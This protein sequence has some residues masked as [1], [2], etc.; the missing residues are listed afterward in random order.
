M[1]EQMQVQGRQLTLSEMTHI[2]MRDSNK[3]ADLLP[4][5]VTGIDTVRLVP[6]P[7]PVP[8]PEKKSPVPK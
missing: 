7:V 2:T 8:E 3:I 4:V 1:P 6:A 5:V